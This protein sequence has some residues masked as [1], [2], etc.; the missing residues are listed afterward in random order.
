MDITDTWPAKMDALQKHR[1]Q[2]GD[3]DKFRARMLSRRVEGTS[4]EHPRFE[5]RF[6]VVKYS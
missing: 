5:E 4:E 3:P 2:I 1:S 6:R